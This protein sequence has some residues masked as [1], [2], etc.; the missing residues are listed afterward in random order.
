MRTHAGRC[1]HDFQSSA[2]T[3]IRTGTSA[4]RTQRSTGTEPRPRANRIHSR[5][6]ECSRAEAEGLEPPCARRTA[7]ANRDCL[8]STK[9]WV[10]SRG[11]CATLAGSPP[12]QGAGHRDKHYDDDSRVA[13]TRVSPRTA[14]APIKQPHLQGALDRRCWVFLELSFGPWRTPVRTPP[15][16]RRRP[17]SARR[18]RLFQATAPTPGPRRE[19]SGLTVS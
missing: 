12:R 3:R 6:R 11:A 14:C 15:P 17:R 4:T 16:A 1:P 9:S 2:L 18:T 13:V 10:S 5:A 8:H 7:T 19:G